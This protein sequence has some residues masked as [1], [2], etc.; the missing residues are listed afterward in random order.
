M[1]EA[2]A[3]QSDFSF[4]LFG[5]IAAHAATRGAETAL[6]SI[7]PAGRESINWERFAAEIR[8]LSAEI[9][10]R[11]V[12]PGDRVAILMENQPRWGVAFIAA[13]GAGAIAVPLDTMASISTLA[14]VTDHSQAALLIASPRFRDEAREIADGTS[15]V[16][17][18]ILTDELQPGANAAEI[19]LPLARRNPDDHA[20][21]LYTGGTTGKP[22]GVLLSFRNLARSIMDMLQVFPLGPS[23]RVL[24]VLPL[25]HIMPLLANLLAPVFTGCRVIY[26]NLLDPES[27]RRTFEQERIT[28]FLCV[29]QFYYQ[30]ERRIR[31]E[32]SRQPSAKRRAFG[33][34]LGIAG[35]LRRRFGWRAGRIFF[36]PIHARF[37]GQL[38]AFGVGGAYFNPKSA[39]FFADLGFQMFQA[40]GLTECSGL[41]TVTPLDRNGGLSSGRP[42]EHCE[43]RIVNPDAKG[44]GE[45][46]IRGENVMQAYWRDPEATASAIQNGWLSTGDLGRF[47][48]SGALHLTGRAKDVIVLSSGKN[49][50]PEELEEYFQAKCDL[51]HEICL[52]GVEEA[53]GA[54]LHCAVYPKPGVPEAGRVRDQI[55]AAS[56]R[57]PAYKRPAGVKIFDAP[58][59]RTT[60]RKLQRFRIRELAAM[61]THKDAAIE[62]APLD[63]VEQAVADLIRKMRPQI[64]G[65]EPATHLEFDLRLN[66][67]ERVELL[68]NIEQAFGIPMDGSRSGEYSTVEDLAELVRRQSSTEVRES[69]WTDWTELIRSPLSPREVSVARQYLRRRIFLERFWFAAGRALN[70]C[71]RTLFRLR[72]R[73]ES[74]FPEPPFLIC[75]NHASFLDTPA[76]VSTMPYATFSRLFLLGLSH[77]FRA[78]AMR[79][80]AGMCRIVPVDADRNLMSGM[81]MARAGLERGLILWVYPE[82]TR[83]QDGKVQP[84]QKGPALLA[85]ALRV[86]VVPMGIA[87]THD[88]WPRGAFIRKLAPIAIVTGKPMIPGDG[89]SADEFNRRLGDSIARLVEA[90]EGLRR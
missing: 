11:G 56:R 35:M 9:A 4:D 85:A 60:T 14:G 51:I 2:A 70:L 36:R 12:Q 54:H 83:A 52:V 84:L 40:Y 68:S 5:P 86:P 38:R 63:P 31:D 34:L 32:I 30:I 79:Q 29:P 33:V 77:Y 88:V 41:A 78:P 27:L 10:G 48:A 37:G 26:L 71:L 19:P 21:I 61:A 22:K 13:L 1:A 6:E 47:D 7:G 64:A 45:I 73:R 67:L 72:V 89:E 75:P 17:H 24:S 59:P 20:A 65:L 74:D 25:F 82:G 42:V 49:V 53:D 50:F 87:G 43:V 58:L 18:V 57:L 90:A 39:A 55:A 8:Y 46:L 23:D 15:S 44:I 69:N 3:R 28:A 81:R 80:L 76:A 16:S 62:V 66:S